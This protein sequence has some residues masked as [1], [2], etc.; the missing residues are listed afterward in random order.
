MECGCHGHSHCPNATE[1]G[2]MV[3]LDCIHNTQ[4][5]L[6]M[7]WNPSNLDTVPRV[8]YFGLAVTTALFIEVSLIR[9]VPIRGTLV[10][11]F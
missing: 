6:S 11:L 9:R 2:R 3:C 4:V 5:C 10:C 8:H 1:A 7:R